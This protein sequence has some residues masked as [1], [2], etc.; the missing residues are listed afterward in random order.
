MTFLFLSPFLSILGWF[1]GRSVVKNRWYTRKLEKNATHDDMTGLLNHQGGMEQLDYLINLMAR[2]E[3]IL[4]AAFLDLNELK[5]VNDTMGH[6]LGDRL[7]I[8]LSLSIQH[9]VRNSD[10]AARIGGDEF[11]IFF[12]DLDKENSRMVLERIKEEFTKRSLEVLG[13][14][15]HF[16][17]GLSQWIPE[18]DTAESFIARADKA[19]YKMKMHMRRGLS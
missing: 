9:A 12:P 4:C 17:W 15:S 11:V 3:N 5:V 2:G 19:M 13:W 10:V 18:K 1:L 7:I 8:A 6:E 16:S 14:I